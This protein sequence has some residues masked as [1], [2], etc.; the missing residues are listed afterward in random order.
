MRSVPTLLLVVLLAAC[1]SGI[2]DAERPTL[3]GEWRGQGRTA[4][5][6]A[7]TVALDLSEAD[8][9]VGGQA[10]ITGPSASVETG[11]EGDNEYPNVRLDFTRDAYVTLRF[12][13]R[14]VGVRTDSVVGRL[15]GSGF[16]ND[17]L[18]IVRK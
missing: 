7:F 12:E 1:G 17:S 5:D 2:S 4:G 9:T 3:R 16:N 10:T 18:L 6:A 13:G 15:T 11:V 14:F 8:G